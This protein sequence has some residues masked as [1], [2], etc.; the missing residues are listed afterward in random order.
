MFVT[1]C[2]RT[3]AAHPHQTSGHKVITD[4][5]TTPIDNEI[6]VCGCHIEKSDSL[7]LDLQP[8]PLPQSLVFLC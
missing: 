1:V 8:F 7:V 4:T 3:L 6:T 5:S 2:S